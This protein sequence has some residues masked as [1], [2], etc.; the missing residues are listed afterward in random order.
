[1]QSRFH[2]YSFNN[3]ILILLQTEGR[4]TRVAGFHA[5]RK[6]GRN[7]RKGEKGI[8]ILAPMTRKVRDDDETPD[9][10]AGARVLLGFKAVPVFDIAQTDG[11]PLPEIAS[12]LQGDDPQ[13]A[14]AGLTEVAQSIGFS[15]EDADFSDERNGD[16]SFAEH[17]IRVR[18]GN[19]P[20]QRVKT[21]AHEL[22]HALLHENH[23]DRA[24]AE[25]EAE[26][27]AFVVCAFLGVQSDNYTFGYVASW[28]GGGD[29]ALAGIKATGGRIQQTANTILKKLE[30][31]MLDR[32]QPITLAA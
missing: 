29:E 19:A 21:L 24:L 4:A 30:A 16:C 25:L 1:M 27:V 8:R 23:D 13:G 2:Q 6:L 26:S 20:A 12:R 11:E 18:A 5:W 3:A 28:A 15:V 10:D 22:A 14:Y 7:V 9:P 31:A 17:R 32:A